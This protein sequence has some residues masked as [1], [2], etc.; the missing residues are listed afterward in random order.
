M[1]YLCYLQEVPYSSKLRSYS[2][3]EI[4]N[5][6]LIEN[7]IQ[8]EGLLVFLSNVSKFLSGSLKRFG[9]L[10]R[11]SYLLFLPSTYENIAGE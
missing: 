2:L 6:D 4:R 5:H 10:C 11:H 3:L 7:V 8:A 9:F 1:V